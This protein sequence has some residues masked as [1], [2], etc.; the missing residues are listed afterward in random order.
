MKAMGQDTR[1]HPNRVL[2]GGDRNR[3]KINYRDENLE[4]L[5][6]CQAEGCCLHPMNDEELPMHSRWRESWATFISFMDDYS[7]YRYYSRHWLKDFSSHVHN[8][9]IR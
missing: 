4:H 3:G 1:R 5:P 2:Q 9:F 7:K 8:Y 6:V